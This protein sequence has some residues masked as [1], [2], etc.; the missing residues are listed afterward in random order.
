[1]LHTEITGIIDAARKYF[2]KTE[3]GILTNGLLLPRMNDDFWNCCRENDIK[4]TITKYPVKIDIARIKEA[5]K[6]F[7]V[8]LEILYEESERS[9]YYKPLNREGKR[10]PIDSY[11][12][13]WYAN[14]CIHLRYGKLSCATVS[15]I[16]ILNNAI[17]GG[18]V[19]GGGGQNVEFEVSKN[20]YIDIYKARD[21]DEIL[22][23]LVKPVPFCRYCDFSRI[24]FGKKWA[25]SE[26]KLS[27][28]TEEQ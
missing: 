24:T 18:I 16:D 27:E 8:R 13:C 26:R 11:R 15:Y 4:I 20:D 3:I 28:W 14:R 9:F 21:I 2:P 10:R 12:N 22:D 25:V 19:G 1:L 6:K 7:S 17:I 5:A 23:F